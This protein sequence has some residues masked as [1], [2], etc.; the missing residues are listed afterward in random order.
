MWSR[1]ARLRPR[2][3]SDHSAPTRRA[4]C[5]ANGARPCRAALSDALRAHRQ[6]QRKAVRRHGRIGGTGAALPA[7]C[8][9]C[10]A[11]LGAEAPGDGDQ[12]ARRAILPTI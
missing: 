9:F 3:R 12:H 1:G 5:G 11:A 4:R 6:H 2:A 10:R 8:H 7:G